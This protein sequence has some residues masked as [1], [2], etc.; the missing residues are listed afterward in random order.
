MA[1]LILYYGRFEFP[2]RQT[3]SDHLYAFQRAGIPAFHIN[4]AV[5]DLP[6]YLFQPQAVSAVLFHNTLLIQRMEPSRFDALRRRLQ[7][8]KRL[9]GPRG[10]LVQDEHLRLDQ[11]KDFFLEFDVSEVFSV[12]P[13]EL[14][15][16]LYGPHPPWKLH[17]VLTGYLDRGRRKWVE[18]M[19]CHTRRT[20]D[21]GYRATRPPSSLGPHGKLKETVGTQTRQCACQMGLSSD[22]SI[23]PED[24]HLGRSWSR[25][26][27]R[28]RYV[29]G[30]EGG[31]SY[32]DPNGTLRQ[33]ALEQGCQDFENQEEVEYHA[34]SPRHLEACLTRTGQVLVE[35]RYSGVLIPWEHYIPVRRDLSDL[36]EKLELTAD[37]EM[38]EQ[39]V[40]RAYRDVVAS[41]LYFSDDFARQ[42]QSRLEIRSGSERLLFLDR[43]LDRLSWLLV[44]LHARLLNPGRK[45]LRHLF[46][47]LLGEARA[48]RL[49]D[50]WRRE[51]R[52]F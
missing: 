10:A 9:A 31:S 12:A 11:V 5:R 4:L 7:P 6:R 21:V 20:I 38:R 27:C 3:I 43:A 26:L 24:T 36:R 19:A 18:R 48:A 51:R 32:L 37:E 34:L 52:S 42:V 2:F 1:V 15:E 8:L 50:R 22:I 39:M 47:R 44:A 25:F 16:R 23:E 45:G 41:G 28:C 35:G 13:P 30:V 17:F 46:G 14:W 33:A 40:E 49:V 29:V